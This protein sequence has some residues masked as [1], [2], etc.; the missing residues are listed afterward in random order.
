MDFDYFIEDLRRGGAF[1]AF[2]VSL[3]VREE[4]RSLEPYE[5]MTYPGVIKLDANENPYELPPAIVEEIFQQVKRQ[6]F[7]RYPDSLAGQLREK[8][9]FYSGIPV[10]GTMAGNG[11]DELILTIFLTFGSGGKVIITSPTFSMYRIHSLI[12]G[13]KPVEV[14]RQAN[15]RVDLEAVIRKAEDPDVRVIVICSP[16][17]PTGNTTS[18]LDIAEVLKRTHALV[19]VDEAY[20][21][22]TKESCISLINEYPNLVVLRTFSKA[23]SLA[24][25]R[26]GYLLAQPP[27]VK[28][29]LKV[30]QPFN[31]NT[32]SQY[33]ATM[34]LDHPAEFK[35][36]IATIIKSRE[37]LF[38]N[39]NN[40][41]G[42]QAFPSEA[43]FITFST[44]LPAKEV[45]NSLLKKG[46]LVRNVTTMGL[47]ECLRVTVGRP[48]ENQLFLKALKDIL[49]LE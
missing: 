6:D 43:N 40:L 3:L 32:F 35:G 19:V 17:N 12:A 5:V 47:P 30:K 8:L 9:S 33:A 10:D 13:S 1:L 14:P 42:V 23:F 16:N 48:E 41:Q 7:N 36:T 27:T 28:E 49:R 29:L 15:F 21:E 4:L 45:F 18:L 31:L 46:I 37:T 25:L 2:N 20:G 26:I 38:A 22:F 11:A 39:L 24:G 34:V 44:S